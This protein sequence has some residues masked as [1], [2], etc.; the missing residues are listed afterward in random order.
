M[1]SSLVVHDNKITYERGAVFIICL[2]LLHYIVCMLR[3]EFKFSVSQEY[4]G[5]LP[6]KKVIHLN[7]NYY[8]LG[9]I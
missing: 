4:L 9:T 3:T 2:L 1:S 8:I 7:Y 5:D 6:S